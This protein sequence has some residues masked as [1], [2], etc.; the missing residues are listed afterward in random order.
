[1]S[2]EPRICAIGTYLPERR[3]SNREKAKAFGFQDDFLDDALGIVSRSVKEGDETSSDLCVRAYADLTQRAEIDPALIQLVAVVTQNPDLKI[4]HTAAIVHNKLGCSKSCMTFDISQG[5]AGYC[6]GVAVVTGLMETANLDHALLFTSDSYADIID[7]NDKDV[8]LIFGDAST[9]TY[10]AREGTGYRLTDANFGTLPDSHDCLRCEDFFRMDGHRVFN[11]AARNVPPSISE[12][13]ERND[14]SPID[15]DRFVL[16]Q[17]SK[18]I[19]QFVGTRL[20]VEQERVPFAAAEYGNTVSSSIPLLLQDYVTACED[21][22]I[23]LSGFGVG[24]SW[25][26]NLLDVV[27]A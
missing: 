18:Y 3:E 25:G 14:L 22:R 20:K 27:R 21:S 9:A 23:L 15:V 1:M 12:L 11:Y 17:A 16:H 6:H 24:F 8:A 2:K 4:P 7:P 26:N 19:V 13:L 5:C 10:F